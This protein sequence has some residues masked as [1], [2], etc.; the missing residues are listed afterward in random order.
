MDGSG[1]SAAGQAVGELSGQNR[2]LRQ[3]NY[4]PLSNGMDAPTLN[5]IN[6]PKWMCRATT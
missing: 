6:V 5:G 1:H 4:L 2:A 3:A